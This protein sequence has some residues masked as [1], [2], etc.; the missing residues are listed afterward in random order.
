MPGINE[1]EL[2][3]WECTTEEG[4]NFTFWEGESVTREQLAG[5][6]QKR[7]HNF[8]IVYIGGYKIHSLIFESPA[9]GFGNYAR[10][11]C[12]NGWTTTIEEAIK[13]YPKGKHGQFPQS[14]RP[15]KDIV[16]VKQ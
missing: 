3:P 14:R 13:I 8:S 6:L 9:I 7:R 2:W 10:W 1:E 15:Y 16:S 5:V 11:D 4:G 12:L